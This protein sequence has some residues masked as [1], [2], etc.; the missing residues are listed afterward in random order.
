MATLEEQHETFA[1]FREHLTDAVSELKQ[2]LDGVVTEVQEHFGTASSVLAAS[3]Y[4]QISEM[5][6][7][8]A[9]DLA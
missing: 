1:A 4:R 3:T 2:Q 8:Y 7:E 5:R 6:G 9:K